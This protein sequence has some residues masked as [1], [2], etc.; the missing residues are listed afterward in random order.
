MSQMDNKTKKSHNGAAPVQPNRRQS[1]EIKLDDVADCVSNMTPP[2]LPAKGNMFCSSIPPKPPLRIQTID[3]NNDRDNYEI[4]EISSPLRVDNNQVL[5]PINIES[6]VESNLRLQEYEI[7]NSITSTIEKLS[8]HDSK[9]FA[10]IDVR[11][12]QARTISN[13]SMDE[14]LDDDS[15]HVSSHRRLRM[16][17]LASIQEKKIPGS[18]VTYRTSTTETVKRDEEKISTPVT[19]VSMSPPIQPQRRATKIIPLS[20]RIFGNSWVSEGTI[21]DSSCEFA[22]ETF[23]IDQRLLLHHEANDDTDEINDNVELEPETP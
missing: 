21:T 3:V 17:S 8:T 22:S 15:S 18:K 10:Y 2:P 1:I 9:P 12:N 16:P 20:Q 23:S 5:P 7:I 6:Y 14:T 19:V 4:Y 11:P 13:I